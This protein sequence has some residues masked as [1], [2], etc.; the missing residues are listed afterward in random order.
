MRCKLEAGLGGTLRSDE[1]EGDFGCVAVLR[2]LRV[3]I[4][5]GVETGLVLQ[6]EHEYHRVH[7]RRKLIQIKKIKIKIKINQFNQ[8]NQ[9]IIYIYI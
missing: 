9:I 1:D 8:F 6:A 3:E 7:P 4:V 5:D 2:H